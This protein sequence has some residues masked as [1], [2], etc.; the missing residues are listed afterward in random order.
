MT[1]NIGDQTIEYDYLYYIDPT[2]GNDS[3]DGLTE[4]TPLLHSY[5]LKSK[6]LGQNI[7]E[8]CLFLFIEG[9]HNLTISAYGALC[10]P[11]VYKTCYFVANPKTTKFYITKDINYDTET[12]YKSAIY[13]DNSYSGVSS[14]SVIAPQSYLIGLNVTATTSAGVT[15]WSAGSNSFINVRAPYNSGVLVYPLNC[16]FSL[17]GQ[18]LGLYNS[19][20]NS[21]SFQNCS[22]SATAISAYSG[23]SA[24]GCATNGFSISGGLVAD[25]FDEDI[26][27]IIG[28]AIN[29]DYGVYSGT[30]SWDQFTASIPFFIKDDN[31]FW[32]IVEGAL[33]E[34]GDITQEE[35]LRER[36]LTAADLDLIRDNLTNPVL[37]STSEGSVN[38]SAS[39]L[40]AADNIQLLIP[41]GDIPI[42]FA[43]EINGF[44]FA[45]E[46]DVRRLVSVDSG[47]SWQYWD[48]TNEVWGVYPADPLTDDK[49]DVWTLANTTLALNSLSAE[50]W[51]TL[52]PSELLDKHIRFLTILSQQTLSDTTKTKSVSV[53]AVRYGSF[54]SIPSAQ[55][56]ETLTTGNLA[57]KYIGSTSVS[58]LRLLISEGKGTDNG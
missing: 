10:V 13:W 24:T 53:E 32:V 54:Q 4:A 15:Q 37:I 2:N 27:A 21:F 47:E 50:R 7:A 46:G 31:G 36:R 29:N 34:V 52:I 3:N 16:F 38:Y 11:A 22:I 40:S 17:A 44:I 5:A 19:S 25:S 30:Y 6:V 12:L 33:E 8:T 58:E 56:T 14:N 43:Q 20:G 28:G 45:D 55:F 57:I 49:S 39:F 18:P 9:E 35:G 1:Y 23:Y 26:R 41:T 42:S 51:Q 48:E